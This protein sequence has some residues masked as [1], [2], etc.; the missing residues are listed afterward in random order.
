MLTL[1]PAGAHADRVFEHDGHTY[2]LVELP[3]TW[4]EASAAAKEYS[5][6]KQEYLD[7]DRVCLEHGVLFQPMVVE[8]TGA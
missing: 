3:A 4:S 6:R 8:T 5:N 2:R 7:T 1:L